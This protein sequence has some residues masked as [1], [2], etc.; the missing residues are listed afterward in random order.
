MPQKDLFVI[1][2]LYE[3]LNLCKNKLGTYSMSKLQEK[4]LTSQHQILRKE[5]LFS[6]LGLFRQ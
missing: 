2:K 3:S 1:I 5:G 6:I 4:Y